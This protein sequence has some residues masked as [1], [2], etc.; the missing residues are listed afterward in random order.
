MKIFFA[1]LLLIP[2][3]SWGGPITEKTTEPNSANAKGEHNYQNASDIIRL[4]NS[5]QRFELNHGECG[6]DQYWDDCTNDRQRIERAIVWK[7][8]N[9]TKWF[10][11]S[12]FVDEDYPTLNKASW[13]QSK[14]HDWRHPIWMLQANGISVNLT[15][16]SLGQRNCY[17]G[18]LSSFKGKWNDI[19]IKTEYSFKDGK[20][21][22]G[23]SYT[24]FYLNG[25][26]IKKCSMRYPV[27]TEEAYNESGNKDLFFK[28]GIYNSHISNWLDKNKTKETEAVEWKDVHEDSSGTVISSKA[29]NPFEIDWGIKVPKQ[30]V[31]FDEMRIGNSIEE[32]DINLINKPVD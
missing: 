18:K 6:Q 24:E 11:F 19:I 17:V 5:S 7:G 2:T 32:V 3:L 22:L 4:G 28:Y 12:I 21:E 25:D 10:G 27:L 29:R 23:E 26:I 20:K 8:L 1:I 13:V 30:V 9:H 15:F 31:Y 16:N 14:I